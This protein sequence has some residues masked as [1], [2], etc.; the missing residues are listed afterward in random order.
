MKKILQIYD[1]ICDY[2]LNMYKKFKKEIY[3][4]I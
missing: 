2:D 1:D 3:N 4:K